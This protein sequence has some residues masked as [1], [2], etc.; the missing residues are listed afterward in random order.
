MASM[1]A[2]IAQDGISVRSRCSKMASK[3]AQKNPRCRQ[4]RPR[5]QQDVPGW[6]QTAQDGHRE[7]AKRPHE[8]PNTRDPPGKSEGAKVMNWH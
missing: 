1:T 2:E 4:V 3:T 6:P 5:C 8:A 7:A